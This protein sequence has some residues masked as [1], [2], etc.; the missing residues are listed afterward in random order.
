MKKREKFTTSTA[1]KGLKPMKQVKILD[2]LDLVVLVVVEEA[3]SK[4]STLVVV[5]AVNISISVV[6]VVAE[7]AI[8]T[9]SACS[10]R[11]SELAGEG[12]AAQVPVVVEVQEQVLGLEAA[13][14]VLHRI[15]FLKENQKWQNWANRS[16]LIKRANTCG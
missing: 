16:F 9:P 7:V 1:R 14:D 2:L 4:T 8:L 3:A 11:C 10:R 12:L 6:L 15:S 13:V 5:V